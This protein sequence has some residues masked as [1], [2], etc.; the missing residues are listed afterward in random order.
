MDKELYRS[1]EE[2]KKNPIWET[3]DVIQI[4]RIHSKELH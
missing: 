3:K 4:L 1:K 2:K